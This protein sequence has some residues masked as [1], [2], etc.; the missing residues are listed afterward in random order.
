LAGAVARPEPGEGPPR[1]ASW[2]SGLGCGLAV[3]SVVALLLVGQ[4]AGTLVHRP[5]ADAPVSRT[6]ALVA[7]RLDMLPRAAQAIP[8]TGSGVDDLLAAAGLPSETAREAEF[9]PGDTVIAI[10]VTGDCVF[11][12]VHHRRLTAWP[13]P[14]LTPCTAALAYR[15]VLGRRRR[16]PHAGRAVG[17]PTL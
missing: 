10:G 17:G 2:R 5:G 3:L 12:D 6:P 11:V 1:P 7:Q 16:R 8:A 4:L 14:E 9:R 15:T 13:A